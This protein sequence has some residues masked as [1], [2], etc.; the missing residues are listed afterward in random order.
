MGVGPSPNSGISCASC[1]KKFI[2]HF[3][4]P[5]NYKGGYGFDWLREDYVNPNKRIASQN[6]QK[7]PLCLNV[8]KLKQEYKK[9]I[10]NPISPYG[11]EYFP[12]WLSL[13]SYVNNSSNSNI[14]TMTKEGVKLDLYVEELEPLSDDGTQIIFKC[15]N[16]FISVTPKNMQL[17]DILRK[18][19]K[20]PD[21]TKSFY[22]APRSILVKCEGGW[23]SSHEEVKVFAKK[24]NKQIEVGK[25][26]LYANNIIKHT[27]IVLIPLITEYKN[28]K[29]NIPDK[30]NAYEYLVK[31]ISFNQGLIRAEIKRETNFDLTKYKHDQ[32]VRLFLD[33]PVPF[34]STF[35]SLLRD[36]YNKYGPVK[37]HGGIDKN[38]NGISNSKKTFI[39]L[40]TRQ[41]DAGGV[42][43]LDGQIWGDMV[44][45][46]ASNLNHAHSYP[47]ELGH[48]YSLPHTFE[49]SNLAKHS[50][51][52]GTTENYMDYFDDGL[53]NNN[54]FHYPVE[55]PFT[56]FKWQ[57]DIMR[58]DK[59]MR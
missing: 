32:D 43:T 15:D 2:V 47:H 34:G 46:F 44:V 48:S 21:G 37:V 6:Y 33:N 17:S 42:C 5:S 18:K 28:G 20:D 4:R 3:R 55:R 29:P 23:L 56:F 26:M 27:D 53:N 19:I 35:A 38:G 39:F 45:V 51:Y 11:K 54:P 59:S 1:L 25:L 12:A 9:D 7:K 22:H 30:V 41:T 8:S 13:F 40:T 24:G 57:W 14:S 50:F 49:T 52:R 58:N 36:I 16:K 31:K 10:K